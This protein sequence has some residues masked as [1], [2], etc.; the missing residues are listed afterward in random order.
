MLELFNSFAVEK[1][2]IE[3]NKNFHNAVFANG[4]FQMRK[5]HIGTFVIPVETKVDFKQYGLTQECSPSFTPDYTVVPKIPAG[6]LQEVIHL[7]REVYK[8]IKSEV[9]CAII[10]DKEKQDF[11]IHVPEQ[12]V[13]VATISYKNTPEIYN[14]PNYI[15]VMDIH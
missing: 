13:S 2:D 9:Y 3:S 10:W 1:F 7:Y 14:N 12:E 8:T 4:L 11:F 5:S 6:V 15:V